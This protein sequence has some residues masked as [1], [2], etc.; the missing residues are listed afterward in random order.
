LDPLIGGLDL[1]TQEKEAAYFQAI[2]RCIMPA[3]QF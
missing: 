3:M 1:G 2:K